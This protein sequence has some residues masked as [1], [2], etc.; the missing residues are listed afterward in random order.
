MPEYV[1]NAGNSCFYCK[2]ELYKTLESVAAEL[3][4]SHGQEKE[5]CAPLSA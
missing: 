1:A 5:V 2:T 4:T 3:Q